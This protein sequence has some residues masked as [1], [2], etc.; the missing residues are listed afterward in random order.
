MISLRMPR[1][2]TA[3]SLERRT[4]PE[5]STLLA[6]RPDSILL[7]L[8][9]TAFADISGLVCLL[10]WVSAV[11]RL[12]KERGESDLPVSIHIPS[13]RV[14]TYFHRMHFFRNAN[15]HSLFVGSDDLAREEEAAL[16]APHDI[17][18]PVLPTYMALQP[19]P[20]HASYLAVYESACRHFVNDLIE[21]FGRLV[22]QH[23]DLGEE[24]TLKFWQ[25]N[26]E[27]HENI[28]YH[29]G[30][31][32]VIGIELRDPFISIACGDGGIG[33]KAS[34]CAAR[35]YHDHAT[36]SGAIRLAVRKGVSRLKEGHGLGLYFVTQYIKRSGGELLIKSGYGRMELSNGVER[37]FT[38]PV[39]R[40][41]TQ[42]VLR[43]RKAHQA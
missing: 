18:P 39:S 35:L 6:L 27:I 2:L 4:L 5:E 34:L 7:D 1:E 28:Y 12:R 10:S 42:I 26:K 15:I 37:Y 29:S 38:S 24:G 11:K 30:S 23:V 8:A 33:I 40:T 22:F 14:R 13:P 36:D 3:H 17:R 16:P 32:G 19:I 9:D 25:P 43:L 20:S 31:W 21:N 41:G